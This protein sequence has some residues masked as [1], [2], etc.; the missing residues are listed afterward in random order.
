MVVVANRVRVGR[1]LDS[2]QT[3]QPVTPPA[4]RPL[5]TS[6][7]SFKLQLYFASACSPPSPGPILR[8]NYRRHSPSIYSPHFR[9]HCSRRRL[10]QLRLCSALEPAL[11]AS[12][13]N[14][15]S[16][17]LSHTTTS[18]RLIALIHICPSGCPTLTHLKPHPLL[19]LADY[20]PSGPSYIE[21]EMS[22][23]SD[24]DSPLRLSFALVYRHLPSPSTIL[25]FIL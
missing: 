23:S 3:P 25:S 17:Q 20:P 8:G 10:S 19:L 12:W 11:C 7:R 1:A 9:A 5:L 14:H 21:S 2:G 16:A 4:W 22:L 24:S 13:P 18:T 6:Y 15:L